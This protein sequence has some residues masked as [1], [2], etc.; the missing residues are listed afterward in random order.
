MFKDEVAG[1]QITHFCGLRPKSYAFKTEGE[2][3]HKK[4]KGIKKTVI[5]KSITY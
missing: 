2:D 4:C 1:K 5:E 3:D